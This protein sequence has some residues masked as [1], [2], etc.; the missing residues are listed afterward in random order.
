M[1]LSI[2][3]AGLILGGAL[4]AGWWGAQPAQAQS[5][6]ATLDGTTVYSSTDAQAVRDAMLAA[7][8]GD[9][10][11][12][13]GACA[14]VSGAQVVG[15]GL[16]LTLRGGY[17][18]TDWSL[19]DPLL[20][21]TILDA[22]QGGRV[23]YA[24]APITLENLIA[25]NGRWTSSGSGGGVAAENTATISNT[26]VRWSAALDGNGGGLYAGGSAQVIASVFISNSASNR[27]G[28]A[29]FNADA[30]VRDS[31]F[32]SNTATGAFGTG[33]GAH[34]GFGASAFVTRTQFV[35]NTALST[36]GGAAF[37][38]VA[39]LD[40]VVVARNAARSAGGA[41]FSG[42][43]RAVSVTFS[44]NRATLFSA[45]GAQF[46][47]VAVLTQATFYDNAAGFDGGGA[48]F[49][50]FLDNAVTLRQVAF[51]SNTAGWRGGGAF[52]TSNMR[53]DG[54]A[55][56]F[57]DNR[58]S[59][60]GGGLFSLSPAHLRAAEFIRN[61]SDES[62]GG[63][64]FSQT[65]TL[66]GA[67]FVSNTTQALGG[68][69]V[70]GAAAALDPITFTS[71]VAGAFGGG[72]HVSTTLALSGS[73]FEDNRTSLRGG[74]LSAAG[75]VA[76]TSVVFRGNQSD[77]AQGWGG[78]LYAAGQAA[79]TDTRFL[80]N[81]A[82]QGGGAYLMAA[83]TLSATDFYSNTALSNS[84]GAA[85]LGAT[86]IQHSAFV[87]NR[88]LGGA[89]PLQAQGIAAPLALLAL[90][91]SGG[92]ALWFHATTVSD[93]H[94]ARNVAAESGGGAYAWAVGSG[95]R[96][97]WRGNRAGQCGGGLYLAGMTVGG[98][99]R[100]V[101]SLW[102][103]NHAP[104]GAAVCAAYDGSDDALVL[105]HQTFV[106]PT[107]AAADAVRVRAGTVQV[108][109]TIVASHTVGLARSGGTMQVAHVAISGATTPIS[110][111][112]ALSGLVWFAP[113][114]FLDHADY[115]LAPIS[116]AVDSGILQGVAQDYFRQPRTQGDA[117]DLGYAESPFTAHHVFLPSVRQ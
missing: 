86:R 23:I 36:G 95:E 3:K 96:V 104:E 1:R 85:F 90:Q 2:L 55:L 17:T 15:V 16:P 46:N 40:D 56:T 115:L 14:G 24:S 114:R 77:G 106:S 72:A 94:F 62:G 74:G 39:W 32:L 107:L 63:A 53:L 31:A 84:G 109:N 66:T 45:G 76:L 25:Q 60:A 30:V 113:V 81:T 41:L 108:I 80:S 71:N 37:P 26:V 87:A 93:T 101:N 83:A 18:A 100:W 65:V 57:A 59:M 10:V 92:G 75:G 116:V 88:A 73:L 98:Q 22:Q 68:G 99:S 111:A 34:F 102:D 29:L 117:P 112:V 48:H 51:I 4:V 6:F 110:G 12:I 43:T 19:S 78:G 5:C 38:H 54:E 28:G 64:F 70:F 69:A 61:Q 11:R 9:I 49:N 58:A 105:L 47:F 52:A 50:L 27:G 42:E 21:P 67:S 91:G 82:R 13:A 8:P 79:L 103:A 89:A 33:G 7:A 20:H 35:G 44:H 97:I